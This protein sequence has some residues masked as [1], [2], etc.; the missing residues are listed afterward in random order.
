MRFSSLFLV[1]IFI[2]FVLNSCNQNIYLASNFEAKTNQHQLIAVLPVAIE[3]NGATHHPLEDD[4]RELIETK[5][6]LLFQRELFNEILRSTNNNRKPLRINLQDYNTTLKIL[7]EANLNIRDSWYLTSSEMA[8]IL[9]VDAVVR[10]KVVKN[11]YLTNMQSFAIS[12]LRREAG[13]YNRLVPRVSNRTAHIRLD[14]SL[15]DKE[16]NA[17][18]WNF[19]RNLSTDWSRSPNHVIKQCYRNISKKFP[20]R[21]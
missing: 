7:E 20:Y 2:L 15:I 12:A 4:A 14:I 9:G 1:S 16:D 18:L 13:S 19:G 21:I 8:E 11:H 10:S 5:E 6:S 3:M 17:T